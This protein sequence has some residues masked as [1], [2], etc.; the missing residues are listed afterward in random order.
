MKK[1]IIRSSGVEISI[2]VMLLALFIIMYVI[3]IPPEE[4]EELLSTFEEA[5]EKVPEDVLLLEYP[6]TIYPYKTNIEKKDF[7]SIHLFSK[8]EKIHK[9]LVKSLT[10]SKNIL[11]DNYKV[12]YFDL[13]NKRITKKVE[14]LGLVTEHRGKITIK[15][16]GNVIFNGELT[17][18]KMPIELPLQ[19]LVSGKNKLEFYASSPGYKVFLTNYYI[20]EDLSILQ[21]ISMVKKAHSF[22]FST[23][24]DVRK[25]ILRYYINCNT[26]EIK[27]NLEIKFNDHVLL[28]DRI[29]CD[30][31]LRREIGIDKDYFEEENILIF[32]VDKGDYNIDKIELLIEYEKTGY[33]K[34][35]FEIGKELYDEIKSGKKD[36]ELLIN[37]PSVGEKEAEIFIQDSK[38]HM[39]TTRKSYSIDISEYIDEGTNFIEI[40]PKNEFDITSLKIHYY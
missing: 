11:K 5:E 35:S 23:D 15:L 2:F 16:N 33:P 9:V 6:G 26:P 38:I 25:A 22:K 20:F 18:D 12:L 24:R 14:L 27:G 13:K 8:D 4:R 1:G 34:Y 31:T 17:Q 21:H 36:L 28:S 30:Y 19:H 10:V 7:G 32:K 37:F 40:I 29:F 3:L 39:L